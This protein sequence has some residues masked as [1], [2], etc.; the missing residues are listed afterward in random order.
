LVWNR[1]VFFFGIEAA[2]VLAGNLPSPC[3]TTVHL[4]PARF[5]FYHPQL[6]FVFIAFTGKTGE[7]QM[8]IYLDVCCLCRP[9]DARTHP[10]IHLEMEAIVAILDRCRSGWDLVSSDV[11]SYEIL[12]IR[13]QRRLLNIRKIL[14]LAKE[15]VEWDDWLEGRAAEL[16]V[17][18]IDAMDA[19]H[20]ACAE[21]A[22]AL[23]LTTDDAII[24]TIKTTGI[25]ISVRVCNPV[26]WYLEVKDS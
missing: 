2:A 22:G 5:R 16:A 19:L 8:K 26:E 20:I 9:F 4:H 14:A 13:D 6:P 1:G 17:A 12:Q 11:I 10:R 7:L 3:I 21:Q 25:N 18:G 24:K 23:F 15:T